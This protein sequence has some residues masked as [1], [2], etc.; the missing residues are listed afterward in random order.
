MLETN[1]FNV[2]F[3]AAAGIINGHVHYCFLCVDRYGKQ[4]GIHVWHCAL[5]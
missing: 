5:L 1:Y 2:D 4:D 3:Y